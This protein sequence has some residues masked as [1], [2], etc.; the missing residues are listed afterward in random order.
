MNE[1]WQPVPGMEDR[2]EVSDLGRVRHTRYLKPWVDRDGY[3]WITVRLDKETKRNFPVHHLVLKAFIGEPE[4]GQESRHHNDVSD[5]NR[6]EN[7]AW[8]TRQDNADDRK[9]NGGYPRKPGIIPVRVPK[10]QGAN[11][12][13]KTHCPS[14]HEYTPENTYINRRKTGVR[15]VCKECQKKYN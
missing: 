14:G 1:T 12:R 15:R 3:Q 11:N 9:R 13:D 10:G 7:L 5:D 8:G 6:L 2:Y 4:P